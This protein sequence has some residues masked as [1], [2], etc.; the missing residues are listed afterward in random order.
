MSAWPGKY[1]IGLTGNIA[2]GKSVIRKM[3]EHL[4]AYGID[5][6]ALGHRAIAR[7]APGYQPVLNTFGRWILSPD[8]EIDRARLAKI[9]FDDPEALSRLEAIVHPMVTQAVDLL[10]RRS[11]HKVIVVEAI[12]LL[13]SG[14]RAKCDTL[15]VAHTPEIVQINRLVQK[16]GLSQAIALQRITAQPSQLAKILAAD[17]VIRNDGAFEDTWQQVVEAWRRIFPTAEA[18]DTQ[19]AAIAG[20]LALQRAGPRQAAEI[21]EFITRISN[22]SVRRN[23]NDIMEA[24]GEK[25]YLVLKLEGQTVGVAGWQVENLVARTDDIYLQPD[26]PLRDVLRTLTEEIERESRELQCEIA[27]VFLSKDLLQ[28]QDVWRTL[29]YQKRTV[30]SLGVRAW[31]EAAMESLTTDTT[32]LFKQLRKDRVLR[33]V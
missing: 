27:L 9:V 26:L 31:Q 29:G 4:G 25:A 30:D 3:L 10:V 7:G 2:T 23:K 8:G 33:P 32:M 5:A 28:K 22:G 1:V 16:R 11:R 19:V 14:L 12:K 13:E 15:W 20:S 21:A 18:R 6:D 17:V 24:F